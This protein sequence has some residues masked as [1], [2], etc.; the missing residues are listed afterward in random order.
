MLE[1][2]VRQS[3]LVIYNQFFSIIGYYKMLRIVPVL[4]SRSLLVICFIYSSV[5]VCESQTPSLSLPLRSL[6]GF[7]SKRP[8]LK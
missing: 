4:Y 7:L 2:G 8:S 3:D 6:G 1:S 5:C